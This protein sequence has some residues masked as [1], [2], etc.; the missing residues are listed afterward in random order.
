MVTHSSGNCH[1]Q[2]DAAAS[3]RTYRQGPMKYVIV[4]GDGMGDLL[5][6]PAGVATA[7]E[8]ARTPNF[9]RIAGSGILG[10]VRTI[11]PGM[12]A[13]SDVGHLSLFG[14]DPARYYT[15]R[16]PL[17]ALA[18]GIDLGP[19][20]VAFRMNLVTLGGGAEGETMA[21]YSGG[22]IDT[23]AAHQ[24][25]ASLKKEL[26]EQ[27]FE[28]HAG[29]SYRHLMVWRDGVESV[30]TVPPHDILDQPIA[31]YMPSGEGAGELLRMMESSRGIL[32]DHPVNRK[33]RKAGEPSIDLVWFWGQGKAPRLPLFAS[34]FKL[35][36]AVI[37][38]VDLVRGVAAGAG[39]HNIPVPGA[40]GYLDTD[41]GAKAEYALRGLERHDLLFIHIE[42]PDEAGHMGNQAEKIKAIESIDEKVVGPL[43]EGLPKLGPYKILIV[44]DHATPVSLRTHCHDPVPFAMATGQQI[45][46]GGAPLAYGEQTAQASGLLIDPGHTLMERLLT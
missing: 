20:D 37:S 7:L 33:R 39:F 15:G 6:Q 38:A 14:Y 46:A 13:G 44:S 41:Y 9:D 21:D 24:I 17:E 3:S 43:L 18:M 5:E 16:S 11:P 29:V 31:S 32:A 23:R 1:N 35:K 25:V 27:T 30:E 10:L 2:S 40:T 42:A 19:D 36:G 4:Q 22:H 26:E 45:A 12:P 28:F 34:R 8:E